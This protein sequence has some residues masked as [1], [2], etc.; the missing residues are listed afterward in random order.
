[1]AFLG[2]RHD[3]R[4]PVVFRSGAVGTVDRDDVVSV[5]RERV[6]SERLGPGDEDIRVPSVHRRPSLSQPV[7]VYHAGQVGD[8]AMRRRLHRLPDR[9]LGRLRVADQDPHARG[10]LVQSHRERHPEA[11]RRPLSEGA[12]RCLDP[13]ELGDRRRMSLDRRAELPERQHHRVVDRPDRLQRGIQHR[14]GVPL[15][16]HEPIVGG[17]PRVGRVGPQVVGEQDGDQMRGRQGGRRVAGTG[18]GGGPDA[19][20]PELRGEFVPELRAVVH[21]A[22]HR[23][24]C[25]RRETTGRRTG[26]R[27]RR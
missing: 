3:H 4:W 18:R 20:D 14:R 25:R 26:L 16:E 15:G 12:G 22:V 1:V 19:V 17:A 24:S 7:E 27:S 2:P 11:D 13:R 6:P 5:D 9:S 23:S 8:L 21:V 10:A